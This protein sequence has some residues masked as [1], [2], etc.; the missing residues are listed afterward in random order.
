MTLGALSFPTDSDGKI[1]RDMK[2]HPTVEDRVVIYASATVL[3][4]KTVVGHDSVIG[5]SVWLTKPVAPHTTVTIESPRLRIREAL[6][7]ELDPTSN[8]QI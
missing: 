2:R 8:Y 5:S 1:I 7:A 4:G 3:G 6:P